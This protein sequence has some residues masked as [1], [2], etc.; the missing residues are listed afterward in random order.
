[1]G[2]FMV[3]VQ[4]FLPLSITGLR[5]PVMF[6]TVAIRSFFPPLSLGEHVG[7]PYAFSQTLLLKFPFEKEMPLSLFFFPVNGHWC[8]AFF[9]P[10]QHK[11]PSFSAF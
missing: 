8:G 7:P 9:V 1:M 11:G 5:I 2:F 3:M 4:L 6:P 10:V